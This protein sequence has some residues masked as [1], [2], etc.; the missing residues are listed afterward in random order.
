M[1]ADLE[2]VKLECIRGDRCLFSGINI[3]ILPG[4]LQYVEG[5]NGAG[6]TSLLRILSGLSL[7]ESGEV[8]W[9]GRNIQSSKEDYYRNLAYIGHAHG[10]K[11]ELTPLENLHN[12][13]M[14]NVLDPNLDAETALERSGLRAV[15]NQP[16]RSLSAGQYRRLAIARLFLSQAQLWILDEPFAG[17]DDSGAKAVEKLLT[18]HLSDGGMVILTSHRPLSK[19]VRINQSIEI[20]L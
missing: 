7:P 4:Q 2:V 13:S 1:T 19:G 11:T 17:I 20:G 16:C 15:Q 14:L 18:S 5:A 10:S 9:Q 8:L 3:L 6:K 12:Y